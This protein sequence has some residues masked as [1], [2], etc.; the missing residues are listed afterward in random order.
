MGILQ[1]F[2]GQIFRRRLVDLAAGTVVGVAFGKVVVSL[3]DDLILPPISALASNSN[4]ANLSFVIK[5]SAGGLPPVAI[6]YGRFANTA[7]DFAIVTLA[8]SMVLQ[9]LE[10]IAEQEKAEPSGEERLLSEIK[11]EM[12]EIKE[13]LTARG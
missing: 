4:L 6:N 3:V 13:Q 10:A 12:S 2:K 7:I 1:K 5:Q 9:A 8:V 11:E